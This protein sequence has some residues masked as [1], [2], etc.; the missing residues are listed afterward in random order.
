MVGRVYAGIAGRLSKPLSR[1]GFGIP[2]GRLSRDSGPGN[3]LRIG[4]ELK[5]LADDIPARARGRAY[6]RPESLE[7]QLTIC[8]TV[9][10]S[11]TDV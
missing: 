7:F 8:D 9:P 5:F 1:P 2:A 11:Y 6:V 4:P 3:R 10:A